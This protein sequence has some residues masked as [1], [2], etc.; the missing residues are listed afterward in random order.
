MAEWYGSL[1]SGQ[2]GDALRSMVTAQ[3]S[4]LEAAYDRIADLEARLERA[5]EALRFCK[6]AVA[7]P[8]L[9]WPEETRDTVNEIADRALSDAPASRADQERRDAHP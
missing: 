8:R 7:D 4:Q 9:G 1:G 2:A 6:R 3:K 5:Q